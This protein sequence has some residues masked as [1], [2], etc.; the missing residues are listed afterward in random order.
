MRILFFG[1]D[2]FA[3]TSL[4]KLLE[5]GHSVVGLV[6]QP[7]KPRGRGMHV[8]FAPTKELA[9]KAGIEVYQ[10]ETLKT[11]DVVSKLAALK[12]DL[13]VV[14]AY[15]K[16][17]PA[18]ALRLPPYSC[19]NVHASLL[20]KYRGAAPINWALINGETE[21]GVTIIQLNTSMD[22]GDILARASCPLSSDITSAELRPQ[23]AVMGADLLCSLI[24]QIASRSIQPQ[25][26]DEAEA[27]RA[28]K[29]HK[30]LGHIRWEQSA[31][32]I[33]DLVRGVQPW[34]GAFTFWEGRRLKI[35][36]AV[37]AE[38]AASGKPGEIVELHK[39]G[40][41]VQAGDGTVLIKRVHLESSKPMDARAFLAGH[42]VSVGE[43]LG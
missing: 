37:A 43:M 20:P 35:L 30:D 29:M 10:P 21:T 17:L 41:F 38:V 36:E 28:P 34:P 26:Q 9:I 40:F 7:D 5:G 33:H 24:P 23:L 2:D 31:R 25:K 12:A 18:E 42:R 27:T 16:F 1:C 4:R 39:D 11:A 3:A 8:V 32:K 19:I 22:S 14:I 6:T 13:F 15:G